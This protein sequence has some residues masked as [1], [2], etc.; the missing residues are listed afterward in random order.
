MS[1][2]FS[3]VTCSASDV[4]LTLGGYTITGWDVFSL[5]RR[6]KGFTPVYGIRGKNTRV[7]NVDT[8]ATLT[9][10]LIE[11]SPSNDVLSAIHELDLENGTAR[12]A[13][14]LKDNSG[15]SVF[16]SAEAYITGYPTVS[17]SGEF[18]YRTWEIF[19]QSSATYI[20]GGNARG[21]TNLLD[22]LLSSASSAI[23]SI[24]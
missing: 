7:Q 6:V 19:M 12:I 8:S 16:N 5:Q 13:L 14:M 11:T 17:Y 9:I 20:V 23:S 21:S 15:N 1:N 22:S 4:I 3:V 2:T 18:T 24:L 10:T